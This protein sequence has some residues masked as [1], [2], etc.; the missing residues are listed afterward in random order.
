M[1]DDISP[2]TDEAATRAARLVAQWRA[3]GW[4]VPGDAV[5]LIAKEMREYAKDDFCED[6]PSR[7]DNWRE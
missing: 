2:G 7:S 6:C 5:Y 3:R 1:S 4:T